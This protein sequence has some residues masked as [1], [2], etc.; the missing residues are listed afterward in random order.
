[1]SGIQRS[2]T[3]ARNLHRMSVAQNIDAQLRD[4]RERRVEAQ[5]I[6]LSSCSF[7]VFNRRRTANFAKPGRCTLRLRRGAGVI[8]GRPLHPKSVQRERRVG[9]SAGL[10]LMFDPLQRLLD[11]A[12]EDVFGGSLIFERDL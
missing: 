6:P 7:S 11:V 12:R 4:S 10:L 8:S 3:A 2:I 1:M 9:G 5:K